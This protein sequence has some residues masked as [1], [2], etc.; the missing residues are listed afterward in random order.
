MGEGHRNIIRSF[1]FPNNIAVQVWLKATSGDRV[2][3]AIL[4]QSKPLCDL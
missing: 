2:Q 4:Q 3:Q 1:A